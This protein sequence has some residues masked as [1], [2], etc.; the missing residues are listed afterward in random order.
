M[1]ATTS[2]HV[3]EPRADIANPYTPPSRPYCVLGFSS[4][5]LHVS[6]RIAHPV[7]DSRIVEL[8]RVTGHL[9]VQNPIPR[10]DL[11]KAHD[12]A[13]DHGMELSGYAC[14]DGDPFWHHGHGYRKYTFP[15]IG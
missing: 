8:E 15:G 11:G 9:N 13:N 1:P 2:A 3:R 10:H 6:A 7:L 5:P 14:H 4:G 12:V